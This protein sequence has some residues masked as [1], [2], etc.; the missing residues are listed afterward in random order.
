MAK[1]H[2]LLFL[3]ILLLVAVINFSV[4][5]ASDSIGFS[6]HEKGVVDKAQG[7]GFTAKITF[8]NTGE[9]KGNW[10]INVV[11]EGESW[12]WKGTP[13]NLTLNAGSA[14][15]L[16]WEGAV[17]VNAP[18]NSVARLVVY[19]DDSFKALD[20]WIHVVPGAE[21]TVQSSMVE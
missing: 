15:T 16:V 12:S 19:Y 20:W 21:L 13:Q 4:T 7:E 2:V 9:A 5:G 14:K 8:K 1:K 11:F 10:S 18:L 3:T 17:P 6:S